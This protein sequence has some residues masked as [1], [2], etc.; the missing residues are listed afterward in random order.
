MIFETCHISPVRS[1]AREVDGAGGERL[2]RPRA[3]RRG[4]DNKLLPGGRRPVHAPLRRVAAQQLREGPDG[5]GRAEEPLERGRDARTQRV[6][7]YS[8]WN[9]LRKIFVV[10]YRSCDSKCKGKLIQCSLSLM[11]R[12]II[13]LR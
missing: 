11:S 9:S 12:G 1:G 2:L 3:E 4:E 13:L 6:V 10:F 7:R 5:R 8:S